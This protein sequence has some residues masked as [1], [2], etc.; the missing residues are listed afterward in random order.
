MRVVHLSS[1]DTFGGAALAAHRLHRGLC[2]EGIDS[3]MSVRRR[4]GPNDGTIDEPVGIGARIA[5]RL[6]RRLDER[7]ARL[8][9]WRGGGRFSPGLIGRAVRNAIECRSPDVVHVHWLGDGF[10]DLRELPK[11]RR[12][13]IWTFHDMWPF[14]GGCHYSG[15]CQRFEGSCG[16]CPL[17]GARKDNDLSCRMWARK[18]AIYR[19]TAIVG[20][21]PSRW[22]EGL[23][24]SSSLFRDYDVRTIHNGID[25][26]HFAPGD[27]KAARRELGLPFGR[28]LIVA[29]ASAF[30]HDAR[31]GFDLFGA[32][33]ARLC[34]LA[35]DA[36]AFAIFGTGAAETIELEGTHAYELGVISDPSKIVDVY[37]A[38]D[39]F[40]APSREDNLPNTLV[41]SLACGTPGASFA[42]G[43]IPEIIDDGLNGCLAK[44]FDARD[45][46]DRIHWLLNDPARSADAARASRRKAEAAFSLKDMVRR[47]RE[48]YA[49]V[50][51][52]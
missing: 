6:R 12:P 16:R 32:I 8:S 36:Y 46:A 38:A 48:L 51:E 2:A 28:R 20:V 45:L 21:A 25:T 52:R 43:G 23:A 50:V 42:I 5:A 3:S 49:E 40:V 41:E 7:A 17:L 35:P 47:H 24:R 29:G 26:V 13:V 9:G 27:K 34:Q 22:M 4:Y 14:T 30:Q 44:P 15:S 37:R 11:S 18:D 10:I 31:K 1:Y 39:V 19:H 33:A